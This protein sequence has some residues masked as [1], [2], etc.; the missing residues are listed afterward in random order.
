MD[1]ISDLGYS[2][3]VAKFMHDNIFSSTHQVVFE[4]FHTIKTPFHYKVITDSAIIPLHWF[5]N[6]RI[7]L[8]N[9]NK[10][11]VHI[12]IR[13]TFLIICNG[14]NINCN[15]NFYTGIVKLWFFICFLRWT[16]ILSKSVLMSDTVFFLKIVS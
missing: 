5:Y 8:G 13:K 16:I 10:I 6:S 11:H 9:F 7:K 2:W 12:C 4:I 15:S 3:S 1:T 14:I